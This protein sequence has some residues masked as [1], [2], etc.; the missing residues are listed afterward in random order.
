MEANP[1][2]LEKELR[3]VLRG[4][5][6]NMA[7]D[8]SGEMTRSRF[9]RLINSILT[10]LHLRVEFSGSKPPWETDTEFRSIAA[11][12][13]PRSLVGERGLYTLYQAVRLVAALPGD[14]VEFGVSRG[15]SAILLCSTSARFST[16][17]TVHLFDSFLGLP[18]P[19]GRLDGSG[20]RKGD[21]RA[22]SAELQSD[23]AKAQLDNYSI[24]EG[25]FS[26]TLQPY[27]SGKPKISLIHLDVDL[28][29]SSME[30]LKGSYELLTPGGLIVID[31][32]SNPDAPGVKRACD[33][34]LGTLQSSALW[35]ESGQALVLKRES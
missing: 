8:S 2:L 21:F 17:K 29:G 5:P 4:I 10:P 18:A 27:S 1:A 14:I 34:F 30:C 7:A 33:E 15:G 3:L 31:D 6:I 16:E 28:Y 20:F 22:G 35:L 23:L 19:L 24:H 9:Q 12:A 26:E 13:R 32:Y 25:W 11:V